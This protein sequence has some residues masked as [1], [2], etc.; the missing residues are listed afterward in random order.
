[1]RK[2]IFGLLA[3]TPRIR[4]DKIKYAPLG[5]FS[6]SPVSGMSTLSTHST[7]DAVHTQSSSI[8]SSAHPYSE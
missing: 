4:A 8:F 7:A 3:F 5:L 2:S 1:M 6:A